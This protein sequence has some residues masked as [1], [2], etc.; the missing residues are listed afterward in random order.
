MQHLFMVGSADEY[1]ASVSMQWCMDLGF[2]HGGDGDGPLGQTSTTCVPASEM[3]SL[4]HVWHRQKISYS[5]KQE[6]SVWHFKA[7][8]S[9][10]R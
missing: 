10:L 6:W 3:C 5:M 7:I 4:L 8:T 2:L 9:T 1:I